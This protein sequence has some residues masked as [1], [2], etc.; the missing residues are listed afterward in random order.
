MEI[1]MRS[2]I[3]EDVNLFKFMGSWF[4]NDGG[5]TAGVIRR[6]DDGLKTFFAKRKLCCVRSISLRVKEKFYE[7]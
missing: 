5:P 4:S 3:M 6:V 1:K 7:P 2:G